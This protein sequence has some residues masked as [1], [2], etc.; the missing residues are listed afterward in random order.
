MATAGIARDYHVTVDGRVIDSEA[1]RTR[2]RAMRAVAALARRDTSHLFD[3]I[4]CYGTCT[5][6]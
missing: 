4:A 2:E 6:R 1:F 3:A 5:G